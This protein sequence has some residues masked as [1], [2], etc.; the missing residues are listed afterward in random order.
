MHF[1]LKIQDSLIFQSCVRNVR[2]ELRSHLKNETFEVDIEICIVV[3]QWVH[4]SDVSL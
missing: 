4:S 3:E 2:I 1:R